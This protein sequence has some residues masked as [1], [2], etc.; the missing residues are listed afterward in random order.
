VEGAGKNDQKE[1]GE[2]RTQPEGRKVWK[3]SRGG[4]ATS[5]FVNRRGKAL[6]RQGKVR[7]VKKNTLKARSR[8]EILVRTRLTG[9]Q[10]T[11]KR[12]GKVR[13]KTLPSPR[14][15]VSADV[16]GKKKSKNTKHL[17]KFFVKMACKDATKGGWGVLENGIRGL[18]GTTG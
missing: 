18:G 7:G 10:P 9:V 2:N 14:F 13:K 1:R 4:A 8:G 5:A 3:R 12:K 17:R 6:T 11:S 15:W 16:E